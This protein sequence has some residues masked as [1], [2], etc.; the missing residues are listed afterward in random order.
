MNVFYADKYTFHVDGNEY[1]IVSLQLTLNRHNIQQCDVRV[2]S[3][4][5]LTGKKSY[6][7]TASLLSVYLQMMQ[8]TCDYKQCEVRTSNGLFF[9]GL[10]MNAQPAA[11]AGQSSDEFV[12]CS[13]LGKAAALMYNP[14]T[15]YIEAPPGTETAQNIQRQGLGLG[16]SLKKV[17]QAEKGA[18]AAALKL[19][20]PVALSEPLHLVLQE[21]QDSITKSKNEQLSGGTV[22]TPDKTYNISDYIKSDYKIGTISTTS[23]VSTQH[24]SFLQILYKKFINSILGGSSI[25]SSVQET[26][27]GDTLLQLCPSGDGTCMNIVPSY[28]YSFGQGDISLD[29]DDILRLTTA[30]NVQMRMLQPSILY[31]NFA[32]WSQWRSARDTALLQSGA[33]NYGSYKGKQ[34][35][36]F[37]VIAGPSWVCSLASDISKMAGSPPILHLMNEYAKY[38]Y[39]QLFNNSSSCSLDIS[40]NQKT[41]GLLDKVGRPVFVDTSNVQSQ[42]VASDWWS[43]LGGF[44]GVLDAVNFSY[45]A[46]AKVNQASQMILSVTLSKVTAVNNILASIFKNAQNM[47][48]LYTRV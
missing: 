36:T 18:M 1:P 42:S 3:G 14:I 21:M 44:Y 23:Y 13:C 6:Q 2:S 19:I 41:L 4:T 39:F 40:V 10:L 17:W 47:N 28:L 24:N 35:T 12:I 32:K 26:I 29:A 31:V 48:T 43:K 22:T 46:S 27:Y 38:K 20:S 45:S 5:M 33:S 25:F 15:D 7:E 34:G 11:Y 30:M 16:G 9:S 37:K 8:G